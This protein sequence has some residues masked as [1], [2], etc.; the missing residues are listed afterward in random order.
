MKE[1]QK[2][3]IVNRSYVITGVDKSGKRFKPI[4]TNTP[5]HYNVW[6]GTIWN[7]EG[8]KRKLVATINN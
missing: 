5:Q 2:V 1:L 7:N 3:K 4:Y 8:G 6:K